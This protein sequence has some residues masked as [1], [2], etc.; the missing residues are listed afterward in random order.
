MFLSMYTSYHLAEISRRMYVPTI[1][2]SVLLISGFSTFHAVTIS[3]LG[4]ASLAFPVY[5]LS[6]PFFYLSDDLLYSPAYRIRFFNATV[7]SV[8]PQHILLY[9]FPFFL[10]INFFGAV[11]GYWIHKRLRGIQRVTF[12]LFSRNLFLSLIFLFLF[13]PLTFLLGIFPALIVYCCFPFIS[14]FFWIPAAIATLVKTR[15]QQT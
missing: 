6:F 12:S 4:F 13:T 1:I 14:T 9:V 7:L 15:G 11:L 3:I 2:L 5:S 8:S 10:A